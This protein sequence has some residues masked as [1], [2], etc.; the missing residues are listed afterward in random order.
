[1]C[2]SDLRELPPGLS[3]AFSKNPDRAKQWAALIQRVS[4]TTGPANLADT[5]LDL[6]L[7]VTPLFARLVAKQNQ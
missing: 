2:S 5:V 4:E 7:Y 6:A 1:M 3:P